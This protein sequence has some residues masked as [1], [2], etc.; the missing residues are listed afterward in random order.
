MKISFTAPFNQIFFDTKHQGTLV[1]LEALGMTLKDKKLQDVTVTIELPKRPRST[2]YRSQNSHV[3]GHCESI[4]EQLETYSQDEVY[5]A[6]KRM[7]VAEFGYPS[8]LNEMDGKE[9]PLQQRNATVEEANL[10]IKMCH[11]FADT[12]GLWL[13]EYEDKKAVK[14]IGGKR[15]EE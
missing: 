6:I 12:H 8:R 9:A 14:M 3:R 11:H 1:K 2:G 15:I 13:I 7:A 4:A 10:L 5:E